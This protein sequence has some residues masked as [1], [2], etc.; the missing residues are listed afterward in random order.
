MS[1]RPS[2]S[3][4]FLLLLAL[5]L[6]S[7]SGA[8]VLAQS[9]FGDAPDGVTASYPGFPGV[10]GAYPT[11]T[12]T[13]STRFPGNV[14]IEH[15]ITTQIRIGGVASVTTLELTPNVTDLDIDDSG[16]YVWISLTGIPSGAAISVP[17]TID[18]SAPIGPY[19]LNVLI[20]QNNDGEWKDTP[21]LREWAVRDRPIDQAPG[22]TRRHSVPVWWSSSLMLLPKWVRITVSDV[23]VGSLMMWGPDGWDGSTPPDS[24]PVLSVGETEDRFIGGTYPG[25]AGPGGGPPPGPGGGGILGGAGGGAI[26][27]GIPGGGGGGAAPGACEIAMDCRPKSLTLPCGD[28]GTIECTIEY[29]S[30]NCP[31]IVSVGNTQCNVM[32]GPRFIRRLRGV[33]PRAVVSPS[34]DCTTVGP[35]MRDAVL[36]FSVTFPPPCDEQIGRKERWTFDLDHDPD[37]VYGIVGPDEREGIILSSVAATCGNGIPEPPF[38]SCDDG[39]LVPGDTCAPDCQFPSYF[40]NGILEPGEDCDDG[41]VL[42]GDGCNSFGIREFCGN[43]M[44]DLHEACDDGNTIDGDGCNR[45]C[46]FEAAPSCPNG[47]V[48]HVL[49]QCDDGNSTDG[50]GCD[51]YCQDE[52]CGD[53]AL[54]LGEQCDDGNTSNGDGCSAL[55]QSEGTCGNGWKDAGEDCDDGNSNDGDGCSSSCQTAE[56][57]VAGLRF[58]GDKA[59]VAWDP[60][61]APLRSYDL[62]RGDLDELHSSGGDLDGA[63]SVCLETAHPTESAG[64]VVDPAP[65]GAFY[66]L[67]RVDPDWPAVVTWEPGAPAVGAVGLRD[68]LPTVCD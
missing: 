58:L 60:V 5:A 35:G 63:G 27:K 51:A 34:W 1:S 52:L 38:E 49:E 6:T 26:G 18:A 13:A 43:M 10:M 33:G 20:D 61:I 53:K 44:L 39:N 67:A 62:L 46:Q 25:T 66:Y 65:G 41:N 36:S 9:D 45:F 68:S 37:G 14:G 30:G 4:N 50:D 47:A 28:F 54:D 57:H 31:A 40:A 24:P 3:T 17:V 59:T 7:V 56:V 8:T 21:S 42:S 32:V 11:L 29:L 55:C 2:R 15:D 23:A 22:T 48:D 19:Y 64:A 16:A 12:T